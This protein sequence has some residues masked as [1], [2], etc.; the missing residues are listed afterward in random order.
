MNIRIY[1]YIFLTI[2]FI[3]SFYTFFIPYVRHSHSKIMEYTLSESV[4]KTFNESIQF[5]ME[6]PYEN[7]SLC[8]D[9]SEKVIIKT[10]PKKVIN[11]LQ[12]MGDKNGLQAII[13]HNVPIDRIIPETP[14]DG[15]RSTEKS[16]IS[17]SLLLGLCGL[18]D[19]D[20]FLTFANAHMLSKDSKLKNSPLVIH[21]IIPLDDERS[22]LTHSSSG[23]AVSFDPHTEAVQCTRPI[24]FFMLYCLRGDPKVA[25]NLIFLD[26]LLFFIKQH[27]MSDLSYQE[28]VAELKKPQFI[29]RNSADIT[30]SFFE[31][32]LPILIEEDEERIFRFDSNGARVEGIN[33]TAQK[34]VKYLKK[35][36]NDEDFNAYYVRKFYLKSRDLLIF[37][38]LQILHARDAFTL[39]PHNWRWLQR[40]YCCAY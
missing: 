31:V 39:D 22:K 6:D 36:L 20:P 23:S 28:F 32:I 13:L 19:C 5:M 21:Q 30:T 26:D 7:W 8:K 3:F 40:L 10:F 27:P 16:F 11:A 34:I 15:K 17:E 2:V 38:N 35:V 37:N 14:R 25:T 29:M 18:L 33:P 12:K 4:N 1:F 24:T 9:F